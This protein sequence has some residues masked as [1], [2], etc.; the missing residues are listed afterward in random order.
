MLTVR[1]CMIGE[2]AWFRRLEG[3]YHYM[4]ESHGAG[5][6][7]RLVFE[8]DGVPVALMTWAAAC[9]CLKARDVRIGWNPAMRARRLKL[10][11]NNRRYTELAPK[12]ARPNFA[13]QVLGMAVRELPAIWERQWGYRPLLAETFC[14]I[15]RSAGTCYRAAGWEEVGKTRGFSRVRHA[16]DFYVPNGRPKMLYMKPFRRDAWD[17]AVSSDLPPEYEAAAHAKADGV[18][19]CSPGQV[20]SLHWELCH[21][22]DP[23]G[24]N[25]TYHIGTLL[26]VFTMGVAAGAKDLKEAHAFAAR[27]TN[28]Q[29]RDLGCPRRRDALGR[30]VA[31]EYVRPSYNA[32]YTL[33]RH[34]DKAGRL[35]RHL[36]ADGKFVSEVV[37]LVSVVD[38]ESGELVAVA[39][40]SKKEGL[41]GR[42]EY[43][44]LRGTLAGMDFSGTVV[45]TD[46]PGCQD[47]TAHTVLANGGDYVLQVKKNQKGLLK[48]CGELSRI[49]PLGGALKKR[50]E[51]GAAGD[52][53]DEGVPRH[54]PGGRGVPRRADGLAHVPRGVEDPEDG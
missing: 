54:R 22:R 1:Q 43:P 27:L 14:D 16:R 28:A 29:L 3:E 32:L 18:L 13:S 26:A 23:R 2:T 45:G 41:K 38:A 17:L 9:Y 33:L 19:P 24:R 10:V 51:P 37:G 53:R 35:P 46:A 7:V 44:V 5:D 15:E 50:A 49:R 40:A 52:P 30:E 42:C 11:V 34:R 20:E 48:Q 4:G 21:V 6:V 47:D 8:E 39:P 31:G 12:G 25:R 36:A